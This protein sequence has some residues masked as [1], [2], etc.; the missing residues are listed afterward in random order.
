M[1]TTVPFSYIEQEIASNG[2]SYWKITADRKLLALQDDPLQLDE[3]LRLLKSKIS[4]IKGSVQITASTAPSNKRQAGES[5]KT[6]NFLI[7]TEETP[8][9]GPPMNTASSYHTPKYESLQ[10]EILNLEREKLALKYALEREQDKFIE[11]ER[12]YNELLSETEDAEE[13]PIAGMI[14]PKAIETILISLFTN[15]MAAQAP[16]PINGPPADVYAEFKR[17]EPDADRLL[18]AILNVIKKDPGTYQTIKNIL[19]TS[20]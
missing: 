17:T 16:A 5:F 2:L 8:I 4:E 11:L 15:N 3:S 19:L 12:K 13:N 6:R 9:T 20:Y 1:A 14:S 7:N 18:Q 10:H